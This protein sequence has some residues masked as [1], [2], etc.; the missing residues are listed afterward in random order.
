VFVSP[1]HIIAWLLE[2]RYVMFF[3]L[4]V[5]EG[6]IVTVLAA[7][8]SS[9]G[10]FNVFAV[11]AIAML[12]DV[13][14]DSLYYV[15]GRFCGRALLTRW[16]K[17]IGMGEERMRRVEKVLNEH[18]GKAL[19]VAKLTHATGMWVLM[20]SGAS[21]VPFV[22]YLWFNSIAAIPKVA[23]F[24]V[25]GYFFGRGYARIGHTLDA[26][27]FAVVALALVLLF[28]IFLVRRRSAMSADA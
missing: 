11:Y 9:M 28:V 5:V 13:I 27:S 22:P 16:G 2:Y 18:K 15:L 23:L 20:A 7:F 25:L 17:H 24:V 8:L 12:G 4:T 6:P 1:E 21:R 26:A 14:G 19:M 3:F 10:Y